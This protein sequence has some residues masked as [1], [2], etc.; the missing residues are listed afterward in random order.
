MRN[1][2][3]MSIEDWLEIELRLNVIWG[4]IDGEG[5]TET[6]SEKEDKRKAEF[7]WRTRSKT[8]LSC[9]KGLDKRGDG[10]IDESLLDAGGFS[11]FQWDARKDC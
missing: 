9:S 8:R 4:M 6:Y 7:I 11:Y 5:E 10:E 1:P 3:E 2:R